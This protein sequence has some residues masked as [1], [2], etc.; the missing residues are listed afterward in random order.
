VPA[1][2]LPVQPN[3]QV[4]LTQKFLSAIQQY[5]ALWNGPI[6]IVTPERDGFDNNLDHIFLHPHELPFTLHQGADGMDGVFQ[7][8]ARDTAVVLGVLDYRQVQLTDI[9]SRLNLPLI[10]ISEYTLQTRNQIDQ[11]E[12]A[13]PLRRWVRR[14]RETKIEKAFQYAVQNCTGMQCNGTPTFEA[15]SPL[16]KNSL[17][18]FDSRVSADSLATDLDLQTKTA[19]VL[20]GAPLRLAFSGRLAKMKG[21]DHL[22]HIAD[23]LR[24]RGVSFALDIFGAGPEESAIRQYIEKWQLNNQVHLHGVVDFA[25]EL[26]P[27]IT[28]NTDLFVC[29]HRQGDPSCTYL[30]TFSCAT[31]IVGYDNEAF[32]GLLRQAPIGWQVKMND[33][34]AMADQIAFLDKH[35]DKLATAMRAA[36]TFAAHNTFEQTIRKRIDHLR[37]CSRPV[38]PS[39]GLTALAAE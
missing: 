10:Y 1:V 5:A 19:H 16:N 2:Q 24:K 33:V 22:P 4:R 13:N 25:K 39:N 11:A 15:Y 3:G 26:I 38:V 30:E 29:C 12:C 23:A 32:A 36:H 34:T 27:S 20:K 37:A 28:R 6:S 17:L 7:E 14:R 21:A 8:L 9:C 18:F 31:P 35:R